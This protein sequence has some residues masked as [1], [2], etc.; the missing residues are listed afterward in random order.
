MTSLFLKKEYDIIR[1]ADKAKKN[2]LAKLKPAERPPKEELEEREHEKLLKLLIR[3]QRMYEA[4][5]EVVRVLLRVNK[6]EELMRQLGTELWNCSEDQAKGHER[7][8]KGQWYVKVQDM[9]VVNENNQTWKRI[10]GQRKERCRA[11]IFHHVDDIKMHKQRKGV[12]KVDFGSHCALQTHY[13]QW[14]ND[15]E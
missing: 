4:K 9:E 6:R 13:A 11:A 12:L 5:A 15:D 7:I 2:A 14:L 10:E 1:D 3:C 8:R